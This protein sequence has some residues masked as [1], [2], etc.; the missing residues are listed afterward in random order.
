MVYRRDFR[1]NP[2]TVRRRPGLTI[3]NTLILI[4]VV[5][6]FIFILLLKLNV[7]LDLIAVVPSNILVGKNL[8]TLFTSMFAHDPSGILHIFFNMLSLFFIGS[9]TERIIGRK[10]FLW[11]YLIAGIV[12]SLFFVLFAYLGQSIPNGEFLFGK[13]NTPAVGASGAIFGLLGI[14]ATLL[15]TKRV[16]LIVGPLIVIVFQVL[17]SNK[18]FS[19]YINMI[20]GILILLMI[21]SMFSQNKI[22]RRI[23]LPLNLPFWAA[24]IIAIVPLMVIGYFLGLKGTELPIGNTAHLGG[25]VAGLFYGAYLRNKYRQKVKMV[26]RMIR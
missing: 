17:F 14:L 1:R 24:P 22:L 6:F 3:T 21:F 2:A 23:A 4:N 20:G 7:P 16:Y 19:G 10:R 8:W 26:N 9:L 18:S 13:V 5:L 12:G 15:P 25:L 11:F